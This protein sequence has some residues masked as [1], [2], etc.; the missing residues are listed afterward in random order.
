VPGADT[1]ALCGGRPFFR[2]G[3]ES[4]FSSL[5]DGRAALAVLA[6]SASQI[7]RWH[8]V[9]IV[10]A[11]CGGHVVGRRLLARSDIWDGGGR[12]QTAHGRAR[13][14]RH[15]SRDDARMIGP[16]AALDERIAHHALWVGDGTD[17]G[18]RDALV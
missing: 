17:Q 15:Y 7:Q 8:G 6:E 14:E 16:C 3:K 5:T 4:F 2:V 12:H 9:P 18:L 10:G 11:P 13:L 1:A